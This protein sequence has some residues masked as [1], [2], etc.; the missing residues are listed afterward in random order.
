[1]QI[2]CSYLKIVLKGLRRSNDMIVKEF[3]ETDDQGLKVDI[4]EDHIWVHLHDKHL[5]NGEE[6]ISLS[7]LYS[8]DK[9]ISLEFSPNK[10]GR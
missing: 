2:F 9:I 10:K 7:K 3:F 4:F 5:T 8:M 1:M 6:A